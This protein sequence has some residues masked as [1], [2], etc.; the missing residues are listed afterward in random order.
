MQ[1]K[2]RH[3]SRDLFSSNQGNGSDMSFVPRATKIRYCQKFYL[4][5]LAKSI[6]INFANK[7]L[8]LQMQQFYITKMMMLISLSL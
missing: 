4:S 5:L 7:S 1:C 3:V 6:K 8:L 2:A